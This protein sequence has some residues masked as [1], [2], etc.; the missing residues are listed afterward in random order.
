[1][2]RVASE[3]TDINLPFVEPQAVR[4]VTCAP[5]TAAVAAAQA[6]AA[7]AP[8]ARRRHRGRD[9]A[10]ANGLDSARK[11]GQSRRVLLAHLDSAMAT[12][13]CCAGQV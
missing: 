3:S 12:D 13:G 11:L 6:P 8:A 5:M 9:L 2:Q 1:M 4:S 7:Q 10:I